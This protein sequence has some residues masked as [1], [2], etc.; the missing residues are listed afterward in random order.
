MKRRM[1]GHE[2]PRPHRQNGYMTHGPSATARRRLVRGRLR[3]SYD[4][5]DDHVRERRRYRTCSICGEQVPKLELCT[6]PKCDPD[7]EPSASRDKVDCHVGHWLFSG[8]MG[9]LF[10]GQL[11]AKH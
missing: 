6:N 2:L 5:H 1:P 3:D 10:L 8:F 11:N 9:L 4:S 7:Y